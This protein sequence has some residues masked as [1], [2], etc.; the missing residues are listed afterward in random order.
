MI[1]PAG[2][3]PGLVV[4]GRDGLPAVVVLP[5]PPR[6]LHEMW[7]QAV[8]SEPFQQAVSARTSYEQAMLRLFG[9]P[10]SEIA[11]TLRVAESQVEGFGEL[12][13]T[14][15]AAARWRWW[16]VASPRGGGLES[17]RRADR[18]TPRALAL[19]HRRDHGGRAGR[20]LLAGHRVGVA[21]SCTGGL[22]AARLTERP[23]SSDYVAGGV[24]AYSNEASRSSS[25]STGR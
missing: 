5:G 16:C 19:L 15:C 20:L 23:G 10:E 8:A 21:E 14:T 22:M 25:A 13:I 7:P 1:Y 4:P 3:A 24:V 18:P 6:E 9:I 12:E 11:E 17:A 2:T